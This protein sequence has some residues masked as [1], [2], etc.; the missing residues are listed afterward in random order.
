MVADHWLSYNLIS[1]KKGGRILFKTIKLSY[2]IWEECRLSQERTRTRSHP[3]FYSTS[4]FWFSLCMCFTA[5][6]LQ[7][8]ISWS[9]AQ[10]TNYVIHGSWKTHSSCHSTKKQNICLS[11]QF[12]SKFLE[13]GIWSDKLSSLSHS[14]LRGY[15]TMHMWLIRVFDLYPIT[16][17]QIDGETV[18][19]FIFLGSKIT[20]DSDCS[21]EIKRCLL[22]GRKVTTNLDSILKSRDITLPVLS[23]L[24]FFQWSCMDV[25]V[26]L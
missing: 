4:H 7:P 20:A 2:R 23:R 18:A 24:W 15:P 22:L 9:S 26:G 14:A 17:W 21:H 25:R 16:S 3:D 5:L 11:L 8:G 19:D 12:K 10:G 1:T 6:C 13:K